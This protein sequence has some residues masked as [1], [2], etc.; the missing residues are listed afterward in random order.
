MRIE[1]PV[2]DGF[3]ELD[4]LGPFEVLSNVS[5]AGVPWDV[6][7]VGAHGAGE[8]VGAHGLRVPVR[9]GLGRPDGVIV[10]GGGWLDP[11]PGA[12]HEAELGV[13]PRALAD[14]APSTR[15]VA[16]VC[17]GAMLLAAAGLV[18]G[19]PAITHHNALA[20]LAAA[21]ARVV[22]GARVVDD[23]TLLTAGGVTSGLDLA[24]W[25]IERELGLPFAD[26]VARELE[27]DRRGPVWTAPQG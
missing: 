6:A 27:H 12:R 13:L 26:T 17:T 4:A 10:P 8:V 15:W 24:L 14:L 16:S 7:L 9:Q 21:G 22:E 23:G 1:I 5:R 25:I 2:F 18:T 11:G 20:D 19:R 3:D